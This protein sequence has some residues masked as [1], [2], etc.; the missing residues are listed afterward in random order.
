MTMSADGGK[1]IQKA[2]KQLQEAEDRL[3]DVR[4]A[5]LEA[6]GLTLRVPHDGMEAELTPLPGGAWEWKF[7][8]RE[9]VLQHGQNNSEHQARRQALLR[10]E[11]IT[12]RE[13]G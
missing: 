3:A 5:L 8:D 6:T 11:A 1:L 13:K 12:R 10:M 2:L 4:R 7:V 9:G